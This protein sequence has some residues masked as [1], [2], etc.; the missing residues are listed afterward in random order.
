MHDDGDITGDGAVDFD[1][2]V[3]FYFAFGNTLPESLANIPEPASATALLLMGM[4]F[5][6]RAR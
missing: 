2:F 5:R 4:M 1:D 3:E 6:R